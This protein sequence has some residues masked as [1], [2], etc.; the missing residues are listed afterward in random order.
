MLQPDS[1][2]LKAAVPRNTP[3]A[4][5]V[6][7]KERER[8]RELPLESVVL[9]ASCVQHLTVDRP[10]PEYSR[11]P[12]AL[13]QRIAPSSVLASCL[14]CASLLATFH[15]SPRSLGLPLPSFLS[16]PRR[17]ENR[18]GRRFRLDLRSTLAA[19]GTS[20]RLLVF[21]IL[22]RSYSLYIWAVETK[23]QAFVV[24]LI[25]LPGALRL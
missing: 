8:E 6:V 17:S 14:R 21:A 20:P 16:Q 25:E 23:H 24:A 4:V 12:A 10:F 11:T 2:V 18:V 7:E 15:K 5:V 22:H 1:F 19:T 3:R 13:F 9:C